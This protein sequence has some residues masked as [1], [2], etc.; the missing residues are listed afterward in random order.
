[1]TP[2][3]RLA[4]AAGILDRIAGGTRAETALTAW[5]R[6]ARYAGSGDRA[7]VRD[8]VF[9]GLRRWRSSAWVG[10]AETGAGR[11]A[12]L[13]RLA[14]RDTSVRMTGQGH[15]LPPPRP[16]R[17]LSDAPP[18]VRDDMPDWLHPRMAEVVPDLSVYATRA[19]L[20]LRTRH[21]DAAARLAREGIA[22]EPHPRI[23][24]ALRVTDGARRVAASG[25]YADGWVEVQDAASQEAVGRVP[26]E[27]GWR[28]LDLCAGAGGKALALA[29]RIPCLRIE[30]HDID[31]RRM[32]DL[33]ARAARAGVSIAVTDRPGGPFDLVLVDA[34]CSGSGTWRR[35]PEGK[36]RLTAERLDDL[37]DTQTALVRQAA[38]LAPRVAYMTCSVLPEETDGATDAWLSAAPDWRRLDRWRHVPG[39]DGDGFSLD[40]L[41]RA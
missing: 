2:G 18:P 11:V 5:G 29:D 7:A 33:P 9:D 24:G 14:G 15:D 21:P 10:G 17:D 26:L 16:G 12:G 4:A 27:P 3:A 25:A 28:V 22:T 13:E 37:Q 32:A 23:P 40:L 35:D 20:W 36:W 34:P 41:V 19:P 39:D 31:P 1:M 6:G 8:V 38:A 30:A